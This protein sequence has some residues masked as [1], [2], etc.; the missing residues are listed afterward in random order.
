MRVRRD[1]AQLSTAQ[2][3]ART[4]VV[5]AL[6]LTALPLRFVNPESASWLP[7]RTS[8]GAVTGLPCIFCGTTRAM[9]LL[10][11]GRF[12]DALYFNWL[13]FPLG[14][15]ALVVAVLFSVEALLARRACRIEMNLT[16]RSFA[17][18]AGALIALW[19]F[20]AWLAVAF[21]K[22]ELLNR[23]GPL[24]ALFVR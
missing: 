19:L 2:I 6:C 8:C 3:R 22:H 18:G 20:Q 5:G 9:H 16:R 17:F 12:A 15:V 21:H 23:V 14:G 1:H 13:A 7:L 11:N 4:L 10:L 24:Y